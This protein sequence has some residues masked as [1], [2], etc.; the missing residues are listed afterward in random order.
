M[1][2]KEFELQ[3]LQMKMKGL[4]CE[5]IADKIGITPKSVNGRL[6][7]LYRKLRVHSLQDAVK[8]CVLLGLITQKGEIV[9]G[10]PE[11]DDDLTEKEVELLT[12]LSKGVAKTEIAKMNGVSID[13]IKTDA[14]IIN[15]KLGAASLPEAVFEAFQQGYFQSVNDILYI[16]EL[17]SKIEKLN[18]Q[19]KE[20]KNENL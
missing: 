16:R 2:I 10:E 18:Q 12:L 13:R 11:D 3:T 15:K 14:A 9:K 8:E 1:K 6:Y 17:E 7:A 20:L 5:E 19:I 4:S